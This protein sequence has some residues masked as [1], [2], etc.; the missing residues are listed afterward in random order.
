MSR[1]LIRP[2]HAADFDLLYKWQSDPEMMRYIRKPATEP[3]E[4]RDRMALW[5]AYAEQNPG[6]GVFMVETS[7]DRR[8]IGYCVFR[9]ADFIPGNELELGYA[10]DRDFRGRGYATETTRLLIDYGFSNFADEHLV[11][12]TDPE[13]VVSQQILRKCGF[14]EDGTRKSDDNATR[15]VLYRTASPEV[16]QV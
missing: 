12:F 8:A 11:A 16:L 3:Q 1:I 2:V 14:R 7:A 6:L 10:V 5:M 9:H 13:H 4:V 15:F